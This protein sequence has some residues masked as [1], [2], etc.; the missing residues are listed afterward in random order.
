MPFVPLFLRMHLGAS[1]AQ[2]GFI[3]GA[4]ALA[5]AG[6]TLLSPL[7]VRRVG[8]VGAV[9]LTQ[10]LSLPFLMIIPLAQSLPVVVLAMWIRTALM[11]MS[12]PAYNQL[13][14]EGIPSRDKPFVLGWV[15]VAWSVA[16]L[17][18]SAVGGRLAESSYTRGYF[19]TFALYGIGVVAA[20]LLLRRE[21]VIAEPSVEG[22]AVEVA[23]PHA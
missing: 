18:G 17:I 2:V 10:L 13:A 15:A 6:A 3:Q 5:M 16:W 23:E 20:W 22:L 12:W 19:V 8:L 11:N 4:A 14:V 9:V 7:L 1:V 21:G